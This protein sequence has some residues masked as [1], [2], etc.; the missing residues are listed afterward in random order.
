MDGISVSKY[1]HLFSAVYDHWQIE[2]VLIVL[3]LPTIAYL[4]LRGKNMTLSADSYIRF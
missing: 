2:Y 4:F 1:P 3:L